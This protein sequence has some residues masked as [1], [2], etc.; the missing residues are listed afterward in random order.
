MTYPNVDPLA[1]QFSQ[2]E[3]QVAERERL[4]RQAACSHPNVTEYQFYG[5]STIRVCR[6]C[7]TLPE[8]T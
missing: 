5:R 2:L 7:G 1:E 8:R 6:D 3:R 4:K